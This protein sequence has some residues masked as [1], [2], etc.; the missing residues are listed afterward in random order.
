MNTD[1]QVLNGLFG[2]T[3]NPP[4]SGHLRAIEAAAAIADVVWVSPVF[5][6]PF[7]KSGLP[8]YEH[9]RNMLAAALASLPASVSHK[10]KISDFDRDFAA[11]TNSSP[12]Y[13]YDLL[14]WLSAKHQGKWVLVMGEDNAKPEVWGRYSRHQEIMEEFGR[15]VVAECGLHA[16]DLRSNPHLLARSVP[17]AVYEYIRLNNLY[18]EVSNETATMQH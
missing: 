10:V 12:V 9:R 18:K 4:H 2:V 3:A 13:S 6:H 8:S 11:E 1:K 15:L 14:K 17:E 7:G 16:T 5:S